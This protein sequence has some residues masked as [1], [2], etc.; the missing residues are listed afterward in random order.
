MRGYWRARA[1]NT[2]STASSRP[3]CNPRPLARERPVE[4]PSKGELALEVCPAQSLAPLELRRL[5]PEPMAA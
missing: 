4:A 5:S 2:D 1:Q 3:I